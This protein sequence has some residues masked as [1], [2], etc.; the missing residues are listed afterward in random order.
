MMRSV[1]Q[2]G[3]ANLCEQRDHH[4][5]VAVAT[6]DWPYN[7]L[8]CED[9]EFAIQVERDGGDSGPAPDLDAAFKDRHGSA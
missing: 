6:V 9:C 5:L 2:P 1:E 3:D 8:V 7:V 4:S